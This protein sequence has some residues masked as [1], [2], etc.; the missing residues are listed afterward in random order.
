[1]RIV[2]ISD[3]HGQSDYIH[4][5]SEVLERSD[6][7]LLSGDIT[8]FGEKDDVLSVLQDIWNYS[9]NVYA[10]PGNCDYPSVGDFLTE[11]GINLQGR[12]IHIGDYQLTG[13]GGSLPCPGVTPNEYSEGEY[14][15]FLSAIAM[16][17]SPD[18]PLIFV[19]HQP[20]FET[21]CDLARNSMHVG[22]K[23]VRDFLLGVQPYICFTGHI[24]EGVGIDHIGN[25]LIVNPGP[26]SN[27]RYVE[28]E[29]NGSGVS[30]KIVK[31]DRVISSV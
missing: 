14:R 9:D 20:P 16:H 10:V 26:L 2:G 25:T 13:V 19:S 30:V 28:A 7:I 6:L 29:I 8:H 31:G 17:V 11:E 22:S 12:V 21:V 3:I 15:A 23:A 5:I 4:E 18:L 27:S 1:M 24:H